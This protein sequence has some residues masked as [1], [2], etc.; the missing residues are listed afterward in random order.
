VAG[1]PGVLRRIPPD[2]PLCGY[3]GRYEPPLPFLAE[4]IEAANVQRASFITMHTLN[5]GPFIVVPTAAIKDMVAY[6]DKLTNIPNYD[7]R[8]SRYWEIERGMRVWYTW[9]SVVDHRQ[10]PSLVPGRPMARRGSP[11]GRVADR[12]MGRDYPLTS[13]SWYGP[14][15]HAAGGTLK[16]LTVAPTRNS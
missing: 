10:S 14:V 16:A 6:G 9:P 1:L 5:W 12:F 4:A 2:A 8:L 3:I 7:R 13:C 11:G 15:I